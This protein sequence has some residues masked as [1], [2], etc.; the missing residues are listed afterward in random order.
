MNTKLIKRFAA[1]FAAV[2]LLCM[3]LAVTVSALPE[4]K[5]TGSITV[6]MNSSMEGLGFTIVDIGT[7]D[8]AFHPTD[9]LKVAG[10]VIT[11]DMSSS[12][13]KTESL[14]ARDYAI[15]N[16]MTG[17][18]ARVLSDGSAYFKGLDINRIY[19]VYVVDPEY[20]YSIQPLILQVP[21]NDA[22]GNTV[23]DVVAEAKFV[24]P[25]SDIYSASVVVN[26]TDENDERL[27]GAVFKLYKKVY[28]SDISDAND[29]AETGE[30]EKGAFYWKQLGDELTTNENGQICVTELP[31]ATYRFIETQ[32]PAGY[33]L[34][35][36]PHDITLTK[37]STVKIENDLYVEDKGDLVFLL[38][39]NIHDE[40]STHPDDSSSDTD[41]SIPDN[42]G[43][44]GQ[45]SG[46][47]TSDGSEVTPDSRVES[48]ENS[49]PGYQITGDGPEKYIII[50]CIVGTS[51][52]VIILLFI[53]GGRKKKKD[54]NE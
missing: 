6:E 19:L 38:V 51:L 22:E 35:D 16:G 24:Q 17:D 18:I 44:Y 42:S 27:E 9:A 8:T 43:S 47:E 34:D 23:Y 30:D 31:F 2:C 53:L 54:E 39:V 33:V 7:L 10:I 45:E 1:V 48:G 25:D 28:I 40:D 29:G 36:T 41:D 11:G 14:K 37:H 20:S 12:D 26:K 15:D 46:N 5:K 50:G 49:N 52:V 3:T 13:M 32:A 21:Y 4:E